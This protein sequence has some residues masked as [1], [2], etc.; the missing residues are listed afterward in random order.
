MTAY[1]YTAVSA[2]LMN[3][4]QVFRTL[5]GQPATTEWSHLAAVL[6]AKLSPTAQTWPA[7]LMRDSAWIWVWSAPSSNL[8]IG[9][10]TS[11]VEN[12]RHLLLHR[13]G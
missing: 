10:P 11:T 7:R 3:L 5:F 13:N 12:L 1:D 6:L 2:V 4:D 9:L 8:P